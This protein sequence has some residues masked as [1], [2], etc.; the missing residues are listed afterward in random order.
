MQKL[1]HFCRKFCK[2]LHMIE[3][4]FYLQQV[5]SKMWNGNIKVI[6]GIKGCRK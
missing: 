4:N 2:E 3:R 6:T 5:I 1:G